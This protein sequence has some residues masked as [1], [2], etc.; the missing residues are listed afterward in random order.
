MQRGIRA[1]VLFVAGRKGATVAGGIPQEEHAGLWR[2]Q[3]TF[4]GFENSFLDARRFIENI[5][6][7]PRVMAS[8]RFRCFLPRGAGGGTPLWGTEIIEAILRKVKELAQVQGGMV[9]PLGT[10]LISMP[11]PLTQF[12]PKHI[13]QLMTRRCGTR[14]FR[15]V[16]R[17]EVP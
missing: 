17:F 10:L 7:V 3:R 5:E 15:K 2:G 8:Q 13:A 9:A 6:Q 11:P 4:S 12:P 16:V 1:A 14:H